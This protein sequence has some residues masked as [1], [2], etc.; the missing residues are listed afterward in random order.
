M[1]EPYLW[2]DAYNNIVGN[3]FGTISTRISASN[4]FYVSVP[5]TDR[6][7]NKDLHRTMIAKFLPYQDPRFFDIRKLT[8]VECF[9][10]MGVPDNYIAR[11]TG[12]PDILSRSACY[13]LAGNSIVCDVLFYIYKNIW[14]YEPQNGSQFSLFDDKPWNISLPKKI[15]VV[16]LCSGYDSQMIAMEMF[17]NFAQKAGMNFDYELKAWAEYDPESKAALEKQPAVKAHNLLFPQWADRNVG[18][19]TTADW[20]FLKG[21]NID[22]LTYSTPCQSISVAG[23]RAGIKKGSGTRSA[24]LWSTENAIRALKPKFLLQENV[25]ALV[26]QTNWPDF[27]EW[28]KTVERCGYTS[29]YKILNAKN[30]GIPQNRARVFMVSV[31]NDVCKEEY[32]FPKPFKLEK[33][34]ADVLEENVAESYFLKPESVINFLSRNQKEK[35]EYRVVPDEMAEMIKRHCY[36][37]SDLEKLIELHDGRNG[38]YRGLYQHNQEVEKPCI[39]LETRKLLDNEKV[40]IDVL[41]KCISEEYPSIAR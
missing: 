21:E 12:N 7:F 19:M 38:E 3:I 36:A 41:T 40:D 37:K 6:N 25:A 17:H 20:S 18:D 28:Y 14:M 23:K 34:I 29:Y 24:V 30:Y 33:C 9:R 32:H 26:D 5:I 8:P 22:L 35:A 16:T 27:V 1:S 15:N 31:R 13:K 39:I 10:L 4:S 11:M 2:V